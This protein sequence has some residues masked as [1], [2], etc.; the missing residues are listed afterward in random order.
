M[1]L[2]RIHSR[3]VREVKEIL[4]L[5]HKS[6]NGLKDRYDE[7]NDLAGCRRDDETDE[8]FEDVIFHCW[9]K[10]DFQHT[11]QNLILALEKIEALENRID[12]RPDEK[13]RD[14]AIEE[15]NERIALR[16]KQQ[17][18]RHEILM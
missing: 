5:I 14:K 10:E 6:T 13:P 8:D 3:T 7:A 1:R 4:D 9:H 11:K 15:L 18:R 16:Q 17:N 2:S 12:E